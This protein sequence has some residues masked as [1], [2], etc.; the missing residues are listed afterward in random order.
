MAMQ[1]KCRLRWPRRVALVCA[2]FAIGVAGPASSAASN[3]ASSRAVPVTAYEYAQAL[4]SLA[5]GRRLNLF[6][7]GTGTPTIVLEAGG[8]DDSLSFRRRP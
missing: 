8:G 1:A 5:G 2:G 7:L 4:A 6:C 3:E